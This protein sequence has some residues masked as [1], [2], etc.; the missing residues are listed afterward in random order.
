MGLSFEKRI[1]EIL[2][3]ADL[4]QDEILFLKFIH[5]KSKKKKKKILT[6]MENLKGKLF[7]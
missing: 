3:Y 1:Q 4:T 6:S 5:T 2:K 7:K